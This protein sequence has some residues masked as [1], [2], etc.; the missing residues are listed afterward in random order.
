MRWF[1]GLM[2]FTLWVGIACLPGP[3][4]FPDRPL[5]YVVPFAAILPSTA[6]LIR[7]TRP[8]LANVF[9]VLGVVT[10]IA[11]MGVLLTD[12]IR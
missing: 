6:H 11:T 12:A 10:Q 8:W 9:S 3:F 4:F 7:P 5:A 1:R 2:W